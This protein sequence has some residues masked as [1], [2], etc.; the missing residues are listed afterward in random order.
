MYLNIC[1]IIVDKLPSKY[2][3]VLLTDAII[4]QLLSQLVF[5]E[6]RKIMRIK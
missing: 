4:P 2:I 5:C 1:S 6:A 3:H